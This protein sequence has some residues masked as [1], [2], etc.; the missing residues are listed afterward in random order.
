MNNKPLII[1][2]ILAALLCVAG[3]FAG[4]HLRKEKER[5]ERLDAI[6]KVSRQG[7]KEEADE[8]ESLEH[9]VK[10]QAPEDWRVG[11]LGGGGEICDTSFKYDHSC[12][13]W[14]PKGIPAEKV[15][16]FGSRLMALPEI[17]NWQAQAVEHE[18][19]RKVDLK[20]EP[21]GHESWMLKV[22]FTVSFEPKID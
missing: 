8:L 3:I 4:S 5:N 13:M 2:L 11:P 15:E 18:Q 14:S 12:V 7:A 16:A 22:F 21:V 9:L 17:V 1:S 20:I 6:A 10:K 19:T